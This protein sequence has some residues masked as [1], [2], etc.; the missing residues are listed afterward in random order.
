MVAD[1]QPVELEGGE[2]IIP[3]EVVPDYLPV[4]KQITNEGR[5]MQQMQNGNT[6]MDALI[7]SASMETGLSQPKS[8]MYQEGGKVDYSKT[9]GLYNR[10]LAELGAPEM[11]GMKDVSRYRALQD[12][13]SRSPEMYDAQSEVGRQFAKDA[14]LTQALLSAI[15]GDA[16]SEDTYSLVKGLSPAG[17]K[18]Y[19]SQYFDDKQQGG[20]IKQYQDGG[21]MQPRKQQELRN[22][23]VY[24]PPVPADMDSLLKVIRM[25]NVNESINP[26]TGDTIN[27]VLDSIRLK[28]Q[29]DKSKM[30]RAGRK[31]MRQGGPVMYANG[32]QVGV[33]QPLGRMGPENM[34]EVTGM[35]QLGSISRPEFEAIM[36]YGGPPQASDSLMAAAGQDKRVKPVDIYSIFGGEG[37]TKAQLE[38]P[39]LSTAYLPSFG[40]ETPLSKRQQAAL[41][42][43]GIAPQTLNPQVK[44]LINRALVQRLTNEDD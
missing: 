27:T 44:G 37:Q 43:K 13:E 4:L 35:P 12:P 28:Q 6:A 39:K 25:R 41:F 21:Q 16:S 5:A 34:G 31:K 26:F 33:G 14:L 29:M 30:P 38:I 22:P 18:L 3:K 17:R 15:G 42:R 1:E 20:P 24:G 9:S 23:E 36:E 32:G 11:M 8:P 40:M 10:F 19:Y 2:W 7:A